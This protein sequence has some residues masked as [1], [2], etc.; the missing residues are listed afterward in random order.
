MTVR[1]DL[2]PVEEADGLAGALVDGIAHSIDTVIIVFWT[3]RT[4]QEAELSKVSAAIEL[5]FTA[6]DVTVGHVLVTDGSVFHALCGDG[7]PSRPT[8]LPAAADVDACIRLIVEGRAPAPS[9]ADVTALLDPRDDAEEAAVTTA[10][11]AGGPVGARELIS[12]AHSVLIGDSRDPADNARLIAALQEIELRDLL[13]SWLVPALGPLDRRD[14]VQ[15]AM[16]RRCGASWMQP[17]GDL[18]GDRLTAR[19]ARLVRCAPPER[20]APALTV[21][22]ANLWSREAGALATEA[23]ARALELQPSYNLARLVMELIDKG[24]R[25][26]PREEGASA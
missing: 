1:A 23:A 10:L 19:L 16:A 24:L 17:V 21:L 7:C 5:A 15:R 2:P 12:A 9:R 26:T 20:R 3:R 6:Q 14:P 18:D 4:D 25:P 11:A 22:A 8:Q 13:L